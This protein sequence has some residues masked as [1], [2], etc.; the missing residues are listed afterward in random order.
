MRIEGPHHQVQL[1][2]V[3]EHFDALAGSLGFAID[4]GL[5]VEALNDLARRLP[6]RSL[7][8]G[9]APPV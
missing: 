2:Q 3:A 8:P 9:Y 4:P 7:R 1:A 6:P 5:F